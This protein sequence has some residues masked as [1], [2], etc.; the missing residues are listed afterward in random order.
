M[1]DMNAVYAFKG[2][3]AQFKQ[4]LQETGA[5]AAVEHR[6]GPTDE[7][8]GGTSIRDILTDS[9]PNYSLEQRKLYV[10]SL[11]AKQLETTGHEMAEAANVLQ[12]AHDR[13]DKVF[14]SQ[15][16]A[17]AALDS[18]YQRLKT[19]VKNL[20]STFEVDFTEYALARGFA[21]PNELLYLIIQFLDDEVGKIVT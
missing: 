10:V 11:V 20:G 15:A 6:F 2:A 21:V 17:F 7:N 16:A 13:S 18:N 4:V 9:D 1:T 3:L 19:D 5:S 8:P 12:S 14:R